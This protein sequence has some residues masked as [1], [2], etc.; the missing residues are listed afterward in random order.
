MAPGSGQFRGCKIDAI[1]EP[2]GSR[3]QRS[4][5]AA[6]CLDAAGSRRWPAWDAFAGALGAWLFWNPYWVVFRPLPLLSGI[7]VDT[8]LGDTQSL[9]YLS[10][11]CRMSLK[12][13][14]STSTLML[15][16][17]D[18]EGGRSGRGLSR[19]SLPSLNSCIH[20]PITNRRAA[21][22]YFQFLVDLY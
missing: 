10:N 20:S 19:V 5:G 21:T 14:I 3:R 15:S 13:R 9:S 18:N 8:A 22:H 1:F 7:A 17:I 2:A 6:R 16:A 4:C 11:S 12:I